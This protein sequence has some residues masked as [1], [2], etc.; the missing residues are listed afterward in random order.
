[1][2]VC[3][4]MCVKI[5]STHIILIMLI[6]DQKESITYKVIRGELTQNLDILV[7]ITLQKKKII[8]H[9]VQY[10]IYIM[11]IC[12]ILLLS[13]YKTFFPSFTTP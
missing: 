3:K 12:K 6:H 1:M 5:Y 4:I 10:I 11:S 9:F 8:I 2:C 7:I 13:V